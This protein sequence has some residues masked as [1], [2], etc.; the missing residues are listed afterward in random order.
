MRYGIAQVTYIKGGLVLEHTFRQHTTY[1]AFG[2][3]IWIY[4]IFL[5]LFFI[6]KQR[7][8]KTKGTFPLANLEF[9]EMAIAIIDPTF[10]LQKIIINLDFLYDCK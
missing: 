4:L 9:Y 8:Q 1:D 3:N 10:R 7:Y 2:M 5:I 6:L